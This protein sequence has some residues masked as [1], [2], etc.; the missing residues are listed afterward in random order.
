MSDVGTDSALDM[1]EREMCSWAISINVL[2]IRCP[3][4]G[5]S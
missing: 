2:V 1:F 3:T 4:H 5:F